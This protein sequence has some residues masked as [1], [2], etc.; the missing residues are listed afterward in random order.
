M[1]KPEEIIEGLKA[2]IEASKARITSLSPN[3]YLH[4][5]K[6][7]AEQTKINFAK[8]LINFINS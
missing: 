5:D 4:G 3:A 1:K 8:N 2:D 7:L 6:I